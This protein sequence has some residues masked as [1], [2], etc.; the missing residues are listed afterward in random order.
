MKFPILS[1]AIGLALIAGCSN[2]DGGTPISG[3]AGR[4]HVTDGGAGGVPIVFVHSFGGSSAQW[5]AQ[6]QHLRPSRRAVALDLRGHGQ[7]DAP[8][9]DNY[10]VASLAEDIG[11]VVDKLDIGQFVL[12]GHSMGGTAALEYARLH[13]DRIAGLVL[14]GTPGKS[15]PEMANNIMA[16][17]EADYDKVAGAYWTKLLQGARPAVDKRVRSDM[18]RV[19]RAPALAMM[20]AIFDYDPTP[21]LRAYTGPT[22]IIDTPQGDSPGSLHALAPEAPRVVVMGTSHWVQMD[23]PDEV[24]G[25]LDGFLKTVQ[26]RDLRVGER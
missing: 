3:P 6:L 5:A 18:K 16:S 17:M 2:H 20:R 11:A 9:A 19:E 14:V 12:V 13:P 25:I 15:P 7:S 10:A 4:L 1:T 23:K 8:E 24:N 22:L 26:N 21:A